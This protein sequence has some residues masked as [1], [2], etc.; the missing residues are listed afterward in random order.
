M[1]DEKLTK[2]QLMACE[3]LARGGIERKEIAEQVGIS[4]ATLYNWLKKPEFNAEVDRRIQEYKD[5]GHM[6]FLTYLPRAIE[7]YWNM[8]TST[9]NHNAAGAG[10]QYFIDR[11]LGKTTDKTEVTVNGVDKGSEIEPVILDM[12]QL[13]FEQSMNEE[14]NEE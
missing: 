10:Y 6:M 5:F 7:G 11:S 14:D 1:I 12:E 13:A 3:M 4:R 9:R 2:Q 8:T